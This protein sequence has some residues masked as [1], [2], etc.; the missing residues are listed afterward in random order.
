MDSHQGRLARG[1]S[2][3]SI[4]TCFSFTP[5]IDEIKRQLADVF[6]SGLLTNFGKYNCLLEDYLADYLNVEFVFTVPNASTGF[7][8]LLATL[9]KFSEVIVPS[10]TFP[11]TVHPIVHAGLKPVFVDIDPNTYNLCPHD[12]A[13]KINENTSAIL[14]VNVF[15]NPCS[16]DR[17][18]RLAL[19]YD[20]KLFFDSA[21]ALGSKFRDRRIGACGNAE[22]FSLSGPKIVTAGEGGIITTNDQNLADK[23]RCLR[24][25]G[26]SSDKSDCL[27]IGFNGKLDE[28]SAI[29]ALS[30]LEKID[31]RIDSRKELAGI[32]HLELESIDGIQFQSVLEGCEFNHSFFAIEIDPE[33]F[34]VGAATLRE[35]LSAAGI[36]AIRYFYP[37]VHKTTAYKDFNNLKLENTERLSQNI[38]CLPMHSKLDRGQLRRVCDTIKSIHK[39]ANKAKSSVKKLYK[40][41]PIEKVTVTDTPVSVS[42]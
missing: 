1:G 40:E 14:A 9:P 7:E 23:I 30:T 22:V 31:E 29:L 26:F 4:R 11:A 19:K 33:R 41:Q 18:E 6:E 28:M 32:Y 37:P 21:S 27:Y 2:L 24:N 10:F 15:G 34:G 13:A 3:P 17:L 36:E 38:L 39:A 20:I 16:I 42:A 8:I 5:N 25:Y 12:T 35:R